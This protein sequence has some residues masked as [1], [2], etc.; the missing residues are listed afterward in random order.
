[1]TEIGKE[2]AVAVFKAAGISKIYIDDRETI[3][4]SER[5]PEEG[6]FCC[7]EAQ[8]HFCYLR[9]SSVYVQESCCLGYQRHPPTHVRRRRF[10]YGS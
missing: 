3:N 4:D 10:R 1:M 7:V 6:S 5:G 8:C 9:D 2:S